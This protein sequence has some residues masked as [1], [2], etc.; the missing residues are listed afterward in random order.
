MKGLRDP[1]GVPFDAGD[2][3]AV[4][5]RNGRYVNTIKG[6]VVGFTPAGYLRIKTAK[7]EEFIAKE[8]I[9][10]RTTIPQSATPWVPRKGLDD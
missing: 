8:R 2:E 5:R 3:V 4:V 1:W 7:G 10:H 6:R 9:F